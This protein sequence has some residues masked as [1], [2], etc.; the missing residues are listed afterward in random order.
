MTA[1]I[2]FEDHS[3]TYSCHDSVWVVDKFAIITHFDDLLGRE[4]GSRKEEDKG[5]KVMHFNI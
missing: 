4:R 1:W 3:I 2:E 5:V